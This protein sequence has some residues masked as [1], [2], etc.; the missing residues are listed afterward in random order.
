MTFTPDWIWPSTTHGWAACI[1]KVSLML[2]IC[3]TTS[4]WI[5]DQDKDSYQLSFSPLSHPP[6]HH[7]TTTCVIIQKIPILRRCH[8]FRVVNVFVWSICLT[9]GV[10]MWAMPS[11][12]PFSINPLTKK[13]KSTTYGNR[14]L[15]YITWERER[16]RIHHTVLPWTRFSEASHMEKTA[17]ANTQIHTQRHITALCLLGSES[18]KSEQMLRDAFRLV[19]TGKKSFLHHFGE[20]LQ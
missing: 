12:A 8:C 20:S 15:K 19:E 1:V 16:E 11:T 7:C 9:F 3:L 17:P 10:N 2:H 5:S 18:V 14:E 6:L 4:L 13:Q